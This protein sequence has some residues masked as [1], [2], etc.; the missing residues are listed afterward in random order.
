MMTT[1][2][3]ATKQRATSVSVQQIIGGG[4]VG[5]KK[6]KPTTHGVHDV[7]VLCTQKGLYLCVCVCGSHGL[8]KSRII[9]K[10]IMGLKE[11]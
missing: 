2:E 11:N 5:K 6:E 8:A 7:S 1:H 4:G 9:E 10:K 3:P